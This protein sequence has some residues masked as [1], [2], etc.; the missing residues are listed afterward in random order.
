MVSTRGTTDD[1][2]QARKVGPYK[3]IFHSLVEAEGLA[4]GDGRRDLSRDRLL[5][6]RRQRGRNRRPQ[7]RLHLRMDGR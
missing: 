3:P 2:E 4:P 5:Y 7:T 6:G 1:F